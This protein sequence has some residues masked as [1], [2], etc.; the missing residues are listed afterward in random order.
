MEK[1]SMVQ[2]RLNL[3][4]LL[5]L[6]VISLQCK[7]TENESITI[8]KGLSENPDRPKIA[9][10]FNSNGELYFYSDSLGTKQN[11][12]GELTTNEWF[13]L[14][15]VFVKYQHLKPL[16]GQNLVYDATKF[17]II[18]KMKELKSF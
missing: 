13:A 14:K 9:I 4:T 15:K 12:Q 3:I 8:A 11:F 6:V 16:S 7:Q 10:E 18:V 5:L 2:N 17:E 1:L